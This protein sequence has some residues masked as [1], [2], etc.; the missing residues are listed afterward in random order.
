MFATMKPDTKI[1]SFA[2]FDNK[3]VIAEDDDDDDIDVVRQLLKDW[4]V[5][6]GG[7]DL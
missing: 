1:P 7:A 3:D 4:D 5:C 2:T 6:S